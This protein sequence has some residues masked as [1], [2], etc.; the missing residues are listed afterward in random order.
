MPT[1]IHKDTG[2]KV[3]FAHIPRTAGRFVESSLLE[4]NFEWGDSH[5]DN[6]YGVMSIVNGYEIAHY[7]RPWYEK[8]LDVKGIPHFSIVRN[9]IDR[10]ISGSIYLK[11][12]YG[13][14]I[15]SVMEDPIMFP[16]MITNLP[17]EGALNWYRPQV[18][19]LRNDTH[20]WKFENGMD[21]QFFEW[22][23]DIIG[24]KLSFNKNTKYPKS[25]DEGNKLKKTPALSN[26]IKNS[27]IKDVEYLY[28]ELLA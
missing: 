16:S 25:K 9:P 5:L 4:N 17:L 13:D 21:E 19:F 28:P 7:H 6:G 23:S 8:Y 12:A 22:L 24:V 2:R 27:Y 20:I 18:Q 1:F 14:D 10:F 3:F 15:Q 26:N 11:R